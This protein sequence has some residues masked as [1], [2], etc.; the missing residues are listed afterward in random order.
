MEDR[1]RTHWRECGH[2]RWDGTKPRRSATN[3]SFCTPNSTLWCHKDHFLVWRDAYWRSDWR[4][5][6]W[7][8]QLLKT[9]TEWRIFIWFPDKKYVHIINYA[10]K[11]TKWPT[12]NACSNEEERRSKTPSLH[13]NDISASRWWCLSSFG[14]SKLDYTSLILAELGVKISVIITC[15]CQSSCCLPYIRSLSSAA[16]SDPV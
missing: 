8:N 12:V 9:V 13:K 4:Y 14:L 7:K 2:G 3:S 11:I 1:A 16:D 5:P 10:G 15:L 6:L